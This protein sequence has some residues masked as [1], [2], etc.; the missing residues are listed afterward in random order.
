MVLTADSP[1]VLP[2][3]DKTGRPLSDRVRV[4]W[5]Q[6]EN[7]KCVDFFQIE[8]YQQQDPANTV[9][10]SEKINKNRKSHDV[11]IQPCSDYKFKV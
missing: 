8:Y 4:T 9:R 10:L 6:M 7:Q 1:A 2:V 11:E 5:G 3:V